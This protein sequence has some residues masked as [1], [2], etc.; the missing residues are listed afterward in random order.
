MSLVNFHVV[1]NGKTKQQLQKHKRLLQI[2]K[3]NLSKYKKEFD[4][5]QR[6]ELED[7]RP[8]IAQRRTDEEIQNDFNLLNESMR[9]IL[10]KFG[11][12]E[13]VMEE[14]LRVLPSEM[15]R[16][17]R[18]QESMLLR[19]WEN[20]TG[21]TYRQ[22]YNF[23]RKYLHDNYEDSDSDSED[24]DESSK[25]SRRRPRGRLGFD[26]SVDS[27]LT[28]DS[29][30]DDD[31]DYEGNSNFLLPNSDTSRSHSSLTSSRRSSYQS[32]NSGEYSSSSSSSSGNSPG[33]QSIKNVNPVVPDI[34]NNIDTP[35]VPTYTDNFPYNEMQIRIDRLV[36]PHMPIEP[37]HTIVIDQNDL[38]NKLNQ[39]DN[40]PTAKVTTDDNNFRGNLQ[41]QFDQL[42]DRLT[43]NFNI[44]EQ[45]LDAIR[46]E[47]ARG[48]QRPINQI[49][50]SN[51]SQ[52]E[53]H[54]IINAIMEGNRS[55]L[56][57]FYEMMQQQ[58]QQQPVMEVPISNNTGIPVL[59]LT[60]D[61]YVPEKQVFEFEDNDDISALSDASINYITR[62]EIEKRLDSVR[63]ANLGTIQD[64][65][66]LK[67]NRGRKAED[68]R[69]NIR[70]HLAKEYDINHKFKVNDRLGFALLRK[71]KRHQQRE[72]QRIRQNLDLPLA[73]SSS[74]S[75]SFHK[76]QQK[77]QRSSSIPMDNAISSREQMNRSVSS[78]VKKSKVQKVDGLEFNK[79]KRQKGKRGRRN[80]T[81][82]STS[83]FSD[84]IKVRAID[85]LEFKKEKRSRQ[86][87]VS[88]IPSEIQKF[89]GSMKELR[90]L[91][92]PGVKATSKKVLLARIRAYYHDKGKDK[93]NKGGRILFGRGLI[94][95][96]MIKADKPPRFFK[97]GKLMLDTQHLRKFDCLK[98]HYPS[99]TRCYEFEL[100]N[101]SPQTQNVFEMILENEKWND[102][103]YDMI[104]TE[105]EKL[106]VKKFLTKAGIQTNKMFGSGI[107]RHEE[108]IQ[109]LIGSVLAGNDSRELLKRLKH[110]VEESFLNGDM[111]KRRRD[112]YM[113]K[114]LEILSA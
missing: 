71:N 64:I 48:Q 3:S 70:N 66:D 32:A 79:E 42:N 10:P 73:P 112:M 94:D 30:Y 89:N 83:S 102:S 78:S 101:I 91:A 27:D 2:R 44:T 15:K 75:S 13:N 68:K 90:E 17:L 69:K 20:F 106:Y 38:E 103:Y 82:S 7:L 11:L 41:T 92:P 111:T 36:V 26:D 5:Y 6:D 100:L 61:N 35:N 51:L 45:E 24:D 16:R 4:A 109:I 18:A 108:D 52:Q 53:I 60:N 43:Y 107:T 9:Q 37:N 34:T 95:E 55:L 31:D 57:N 93:E 50:N 65:I 63:P 110:H 98:I 25:P 62:E 84:K 105:K 14:S 80:S 39:L 54:Q 33:N 88:S 76:R 85:G 96:R 19:K 113:N 46:R 22:F 28:E 21:A 86:S 49:I 97:I 47:L 99:R 72:K 40:I 59:D 114:I 29:D 67:K 58:Q 12:S 77:R 104:P 81:N 56:D 74:S 1:Q 23:L 8:V 87:S